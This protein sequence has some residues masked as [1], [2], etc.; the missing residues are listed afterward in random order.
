MKLIHLSRDIGSLIKN[1]DEHSAV[2]KNV[3]IFF[4]HFRDDC[5]NTGLSADMTINGENK[6]KIF[7]L[8]FSDV[9]CIDAVMCED[10]GRISLLWLSRPVDIYI[11][12]SADDDETL[13]V[14]ISACDEDI[15]CARFL[16]SGVLD[17]ST[18]EYRSYYENNRIY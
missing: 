3:R 1:I 8:Y 4:A 11:W 15:E 16:C 10:R 9:R 12:E 14:E 2:I 13:S 7:S 18:Y 5:G 6:K 17:E